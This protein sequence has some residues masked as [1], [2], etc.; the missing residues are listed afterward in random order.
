MYF[1][2]INFTFLVLLFSFQYRFFFLGGGGGGLLI[3]FHH[4]SSR[5]SCS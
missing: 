3:L 2:C 5:G 1:T 4:E